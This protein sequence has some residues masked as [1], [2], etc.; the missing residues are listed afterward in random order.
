MMDAKAH[1]KSLS[2]SSADYFVM[3]DRTERRVKAFLAG[4]D[5]RNIC[6]LTWTSSIRASTRRCPSHPFPHDLSLELLRAHRDPQNPDA[7]LSYR[8]PSLVEHYPLRSARICMLLHKATTGAQLE[9]DD[10]AHLQHVTAISEIIL[11]VI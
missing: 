2:N 1:F 11:A 9:G 5:R 6:K 4:A 10:R 7:S 8:Y 3:S